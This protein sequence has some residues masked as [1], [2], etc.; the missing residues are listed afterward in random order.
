MKTDTYTKVVLTGIL[1]FLGVI[2]FDYKPTINAHA[3]SSSGVD[4][5]ASS[6][7]DKEPFLWLV[8]DGKV[9]ICTEVGKPGTP[10]PRCSEFVSTPKWSN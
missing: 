3:S 7:T 4:M 2:A 10:S 8:K 6:S 9:T 1:I 5:I